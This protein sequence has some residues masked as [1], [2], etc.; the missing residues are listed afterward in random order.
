MVAIG[1]ASVGAL[2]TALLLAVA[3][4]VV[5]FFAAD[6]ELYGSAWLIVGSLVIFSVISGAATVYL[7][8]RG[9]RDL[10]AVGRRRG[11]GRGS[12]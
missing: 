11:A 1:V 5:A 12:S 4:Y 9:L 3:I 2:F 7:G 6:D 10:R 8:R